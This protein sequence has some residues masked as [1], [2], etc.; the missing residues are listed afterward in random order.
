MCYYDYASMMK[1]RL[2][3]WAPADQRAPAP[4]PPP[5]RIKLFRLWSES[6]ARVLSALPR[7]P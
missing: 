5:R 3:R 2:G 1:L 4:R 6:K 7:L